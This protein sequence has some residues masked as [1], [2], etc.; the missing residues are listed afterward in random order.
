MPAP[1]VAAAAAQKVAPQALNLAKSYVPQG[2]PPPGNPP[3]V[4][5]NQ[6]KGLLERLNSFRVLLIFVIFCIIGYYVYRIFSSGLDFFRQGIG[7]MFNQVAD[8]TGD[9]VL[10][11]LTAVGADK[12]FRKI[13]NGLN[14]KNWGKKNNSLKKPGKWFK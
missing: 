7:G 8:I 3:Q 4:T 2:N 11:P 10:L 9:L 13:G 6:K 1:L 14:P 5:I 12:P